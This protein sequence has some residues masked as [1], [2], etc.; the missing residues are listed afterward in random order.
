MTDPERRQVRVRRSPR[1]GVFLALGA[2]L[3]ALAAVVLVLA[4]PP[5]P[6]T[7]T[8][9]AIGFLVLLL[10]PLGAL[11]TG[12]VAIALEARGT[13]R[14]RTVEAEREAPRPA[15]PDDQS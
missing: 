9:Q 1:I 6:T 11:L 12:L 4:T 7:P 10:A 5:D 8:P 2:V 13:R 15:L 14:A 3:G